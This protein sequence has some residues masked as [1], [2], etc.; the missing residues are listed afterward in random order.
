MLWVSV[1]NLNH[2]PFLFTQDVADKEVAIFKSQSSCCDGHNPT[3][4][5]SLERQGCPQ[6]RTGFNTGGYMVNEMQM[7]DPVLDRNPLL[8]SGGYTK[9]VYEELVYHYIP[10]SNQLLLKALCII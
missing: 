4:E 3:N 10:I 2:F 5:I 7:T 1:L 8:V 9:M 6:H